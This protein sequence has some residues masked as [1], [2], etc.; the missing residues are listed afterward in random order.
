[1]MNHIQRLLCYGLLAMVGGFNP[2][3]AQNDLT[4]YVPWI[5][6]TTDVSEMFVS[7]EYRQPTIV[8]NPAPAGTI[9]ITIMS[10]NGTSIGSEQF[11]LRDGEQRM[12]T[13][14]HVL[15]G[16]RSRGSSYAIVR[17]PLG[18]RVQGFL[19][20]KN[21]KFIGPMAA[22]QSPLWL[23]QG[24][25][26][27]YDLAFANPASNRFNVS[28]I[29]FLN[30]SDTP[31]LVLFS[32]RDNTGERTNPV[33]CALG[34]GQGLMIPITDLEAGELTGRASEACE[35]RSPWGDLRGKWRVFAAGYRGIN[36]EIRPNRIPFV[37]MSILNAR[38]AGMLADVSGARLPIAECFASRDC[39][40][41]FTGASSQS[42]AVAAAA[43]YNDI[44]QNEDLG[45]I[46]RV[47][48]ASVA[49]D[50]ALTAFAE[51]FV[52][53]EAAGAESRPEAR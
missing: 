2:V 26:Y 47:L 10:D 22:A 4:D 33:L 43:A 30:P 29:R 32:G 20:D 1:M 21:T 9:T 3:A 12:V 24:G 15:G 39:H 34:A 28:A 16:I 13:T 53:T 14:S 7:I 50:A 36:D 6:A 42:G 35:M 52:R 11:T 5:P 40:P 41:G 23:R 31:R 37:T 17:Y 44:G 19:R 18:A 8:N 49:E 25:V 38:N 27:T 48:A 51:R 46:Y 45:A